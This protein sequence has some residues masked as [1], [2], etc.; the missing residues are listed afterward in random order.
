MPRSTRSASR[1]RHAFSPPAGSGLVDGLLVRSDPVGARLLEQALRSF[2]EPDVM[3]PR[4]SAVWLWGD[5]IVVEL[6]DARP[7]YSP[8]GGE[9]AR[10]PASGSSVVS[11]SHHMMPRA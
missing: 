1:T 9:Q 10:T 8:T 6:A 11:G 2:A 4:L 7:A 3:M 5:E